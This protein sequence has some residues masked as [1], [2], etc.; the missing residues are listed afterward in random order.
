MGG[1]VRLSI[2]FYSKDISA[3][4][5][6]TA[7]LKKKCP[8][9]DKKG[10]INSTPRIMTQHYHLTCLCNMSNMSMWNEWHVCVTWI[11]CLWKNLLKVYRTHPSGHVSTTPLVMCEDGSVW[12]IPLQ[13]Y[14][15][16][17]LGRKINIKNITS[18]LM[19]RN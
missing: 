6:L 17:T 13:V 9:K 19:E 2:S 18:E 16:I 5:D 8:T 10:K 3:Q 12:E 1:R 14:S 15:V 4:I 11:L 7:I